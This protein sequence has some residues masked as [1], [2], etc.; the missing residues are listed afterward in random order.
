MFEDKLHFLLASFQLLLFQGSKINS[1]FLPAY[2]ITRLKNAN[3][4]MKI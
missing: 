1:T 2:G 3:Y 4:L